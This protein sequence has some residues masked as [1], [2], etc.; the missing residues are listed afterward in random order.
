[1]TFIKT[2]EDA[3]GQEAKK[4]YLP[5]QPGDVVAT[6]A[7]IDALKRDVGFEPKTELAVGIENWARWYRTYTG[8]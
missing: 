1:M 5:M 6:Y 2:I 7:N 8:Q 4:N 3:I